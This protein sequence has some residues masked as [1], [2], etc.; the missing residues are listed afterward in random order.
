MQEFWNDVFT[1]SEHAKYLGVCYIALVKVLMC[2]LLPI[3]IVLEYIY[4]V[5]IALKLVFNRISLSPVYPLYSVFS[6]LF[7]FLETTVMTNLVNEL[8]Y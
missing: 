4:K 5:F 3:G 8:K 6:T 7:L 2:H 1:L